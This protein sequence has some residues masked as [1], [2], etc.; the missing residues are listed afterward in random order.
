MIRV[1]QTDLLVGHQSHVVRDEDRYTIASFQLAEKRQPA[2]TLAVIA[3]GTMA[4]PDRAF[5]QYASEM[6]VEAFLARQC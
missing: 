4:Y 5:N 2:V 3:H 1:E 6:V